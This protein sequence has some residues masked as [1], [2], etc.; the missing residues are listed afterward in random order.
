[1]LGVWALVR[2][3]RRWTAAALAGGG[4]AWTAFCVA[5]VIPHY[6]PTG[7]S[8]FINRYAEL[9]ES[10][11]DVVKTLLTRPWDALEVMVSVGRF[12]YLLALL[13]PLL[14][15]PFLA[16]LLALG[17]L[18]D[19]ALNLL[20]QLLA[21]V[22]GAVPVHRHDH[23]VPDRRV[24]PRPGAAARHAGPGVAARA[25]PTRP[26]SWR[27]CWGGGRDRR[28]PAGAAA[29]LAPRS[30]RI[31]GPGP[32]V[33]GHLPRARAGPGRGARAGRP[34]RGGLRLEPHGQPALGTAGHLHLARGERRHLGPG[35]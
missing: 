4:V 15:L 19:L 9:G 6:S 5:V 14:L 25:S 30:R 11:G 27:R 12:E 26:G 24:H 28:V 31:G 18:P 7:G 16:P 23:P 17:A 29:V 33:H 21:A 1:M 3:R 35:G 8:P 10:Q 32:G 2:H 13:L 22:L 34:G 20:A